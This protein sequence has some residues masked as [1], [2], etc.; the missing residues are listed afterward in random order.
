MVG[1]VHFTY[2]NKVPLNAI[3][4]VIEQ[5]LRFNAVKTTKYLATNLVVRAVRKRTG[6]RIDKRSNTQIT[7][8]IGRPNY[9]ERDFIKDCQKAKEPFPV[10]GVQ[11]KLYT[12]PKRKL[13]PKKKH[14]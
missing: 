13:S 3:T 1:H 7:L 8:T 2:M 12:P 9:I 6:L 11:L 10:K 5:L 14:R 4:N